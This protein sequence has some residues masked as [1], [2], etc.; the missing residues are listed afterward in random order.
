M[1]SGEVCGS[2]VSE[3]VFV[4]GGNNAQNS[5]SFADIQTLNDSF[6]DMLDYATYIFPHAKINVFSVIPRKLAHPD[7][8]ANMMHANE[9][10]YTICAQYFNCRFVDLFSH[11]LTKKSCLIEKLYKPDF[12]HFSDIGTSVLA[13]VIKGVVY[14]PFK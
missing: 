8:F 13:K 12:I 6:I 9:F 5:K 7:H 11:F 14:R 10:M 1:Y 4:V 2:C 3:V